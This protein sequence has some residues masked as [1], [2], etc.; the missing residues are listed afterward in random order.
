MDINS[1][2]IAIGAV[3]AAVFAF[4]ARENGKKVGE[5]KGIE[6]GK[7]Q[8]VS[9]MKAQSTEQTL[10]RTVAANEARAAVERSSDSQLSEQARHDPNNRLSGV[11]RAP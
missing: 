1:I 5:R 10:E 7:N 4:L 3:I 6:I 8:A 9:D 2:A 11:Q